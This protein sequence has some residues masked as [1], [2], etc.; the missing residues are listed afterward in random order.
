MKYECVVWGMFA[1]IMCLEG[2]FPFLTNIAENSSA[3]LILMN[4]GHAPVK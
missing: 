2:D 3:C 4:G 1:L